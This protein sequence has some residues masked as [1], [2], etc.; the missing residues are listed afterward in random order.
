MNT[1]RHWNTESNRDN[2]AFSA[3]FATGLMVA[4][5]AGA[6]FMA[7]LAAEPATQSGLQAANDATQN[8]IVVTATRLKAAPSLQA[9]AR[10]AT[11]NS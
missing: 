11:N 6:S 8:R 7:D 1:Q 9:R 10:V 4:W 2:L 3:V 5:I